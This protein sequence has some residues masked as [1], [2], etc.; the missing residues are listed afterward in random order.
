MRPT[1]WRMFMDKDVAIERETAAL[2]PPYPTML[3]SP[4]A[5][6][7]AAML[8]LL[9]TV[10]EHDLGPN[11]LLFFEPGTTWLQRSE[12][13]YQFDVFPETYVKTRRDRPWVVVICAGRENG[14]AAARRLAKV[15]VKMVRRHLWA[16][17]VGPIE[18]WPRKR[19]KGSIGMDQATVL[20]ITE[21]RWPRRLPPSGRSPKP[22]KA[23][24]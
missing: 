10:P 14:S 5:H 6:S 1:I 3:S 19:C 17:R 20:V 12:D 24:V 23:G 8:A 22:G 18:I 4:M 7:L 9:L 15:R 13:R 2:D 21:T 11:V 16:N